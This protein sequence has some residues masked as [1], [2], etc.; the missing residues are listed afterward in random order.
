MLKRWLGIIIV[1]SGICSYNGLATE[2]PNPTQTCGTSERNALTA[3][4]FIYKSVT[5]IGHE[6]G[7]CRR[8]P[9]DIIKVGDIYFVWYTKVLAESPLYPSGYFGTIWY[10][11]SQNGLH[12]TEHGEALGKG[13]TGSFDAYAVFTPGILAAQG[14]YYLYYTA[15]PDGF[16]NNNTSDYTAI[17]MAESNSPHGPWIRSPANPIVKP[18]KDHTKFD[19]YRVDDSCLLVRD[20]RIWLY[21]KGRQYN[22]TP[23]QTKMGIAIAED[24]RGPYIKVTDMFVDHSILAE[25][26]EVLVWPQGSGVAALASISQTI[27]Y[28]ADGLYFEHLTKVRNRPNAPGGYRP[29]AFTDSKKPCSMRWG[30]SMVHGRDPYLRWFG[31]LTMGDRK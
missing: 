16:V 5:G 23:G 4:D 31:I 7:V 13:P 19:S 30:I 1:C 9:S 26:H 20:G 15:V 21:Y 28:A 6:V 3:A 22:R 14:K 25:S 18:S 29:D 8:D 10:A 2:R 17:G 12:W 24:P 27:Q 11:T